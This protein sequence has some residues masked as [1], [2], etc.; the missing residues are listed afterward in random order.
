MQIDD[1]RQRRS[2]R[3]RAVTARRDRTLADGDREIVYCAAIVNV[4]GQR[5]QLLAGIAVGRDRY[6]PRLWGRPFGQRL[7]QLLDLRMQHTHATTRKTWNST[8]GPGWMRP[9]PTKML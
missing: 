9:C 1:A 3:R 7:Q 4:A 5:D 8:I 6:L 2:G